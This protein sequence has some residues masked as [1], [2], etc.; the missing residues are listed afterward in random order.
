MFPHFRT[1]RRQLGVSA[2][3]AAA[4]AV[5]CD[6]G[7]GG[8]TQEL[9]IRTETDSVGDTLVVRTVGSSSAGMHTLVEEVRVGELD[10]PDEYTFGAVSEMLALPDGG[11]LIFDRLVPALRLYDSSGTYVRTIGRKGG[12]PGE[13][14]GSG[15][16][17]LL[18]DGRV[19][20]WDPTNARIQFFSQ[21]GTAGDVVRLSG[22]FASSRAVWTDDEGRVY[23]RALIPQSNSEATRQ[24]P[25]LNTGVARF[26]PG[27]AAHDTLPLPVEASPDQTLT[28]STPDGGGWS[29]RNVP[30]MFSPAWTVFANGFAFTVNPRY[31]IVVERDGH[32]MVIER[33]VEPV[34]VEAAERANI[35]E[36]VTFQM[37]QTDP[38][39]RWNGPAIPDTKAPIQSLSV[40]PDRKLWVHVYS[41]GVIDS[42]AL[43]EE[44]REDQGPA[45]VWT[46]RGTMD[47]FGEDGVF[48]GRVTMPQRASTW[49][50]SAY[51]N[52]VWGVQTDELGVQQLV[53]WRVEPAWGGGL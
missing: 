34:P 48:Q 33:E 15:G 11:V 13:Y 7:G 5:A 18:P 45:R 47:V 28:A 32:L 20:M 4:F 23:Y 44:R 25:R 35:E 52:H 41:P 50:Y 6:A 38:Q 39:W 31:R 43:A 16:M 22:G 42:V 26:K 40:S 37:R 2:I 36:V 49:M 24:A 9:S 10:G 8:A 3:F 30:F 51:G 17:A 21:D 1:V 14:Q 46:E 19:A 53:R 29:S 27:N 12:G